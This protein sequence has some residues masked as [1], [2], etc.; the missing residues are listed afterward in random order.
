M[1]FFCFLGRFSMYGLSDTEGM[2]VSPVKGKCIPIEE[3]S[4]KTFAQKLMG[5]G[6][7]VIP[8]E[9]TILAPLDGE[10]VMIA[11]TKHAVGLRTK[12]NEEV[13][14]HVGI[15]TV[16]LGG[17]GFTCLVQ[18]GDCVKAGEP[19]IQFDPV[20]MTEKEMD[21]TT[22]VVFIDSIEDRINSESYG[23]NVESGEALN[24]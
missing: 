18:K 22:I 14:V 16:K 9:N 20:I 21:M 23:K 17:I 11:K 12:V 19:I 1:E 8:E 4:D 6:F 13:I 24:S 7:A 5:G 10:I 2:I 3:V 15:D